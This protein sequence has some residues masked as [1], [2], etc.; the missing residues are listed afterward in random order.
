ML[1]NLIIV[2]AII[3]VVWLASFAIYMRTSRQQHDLEKDLQRLQA[4]LD[5]DS[6][7]DSATQA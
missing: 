7:K 4:K 2:A 3:I 1:E 6:H 5:Q